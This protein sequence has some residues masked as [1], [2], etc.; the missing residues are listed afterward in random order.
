MEQ[1]S[2]WWPGRGSAP[3]A[4]E[5]YRQLAQAR[6]AELWLGSGSSSV[7]QQALRDFDRALA[8][9]FDKANPAGRPGYR[10]SRGIQGFAIRDT[11]TRRLSRR[12]G[13]VYVPKCGWVRFRWTQPL[14][15][16]L[17]VARVTCDRAG[18][19]HVCFPAPNRRLP[20]NAP[21]R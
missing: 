14:P 7:Q 3:S 15:D 4:V 16:K 19:W 13:E 20:E 21:G 2:W 12:W 8:A 1:Q 5:R 18:R 17:G 11:R 10:S 6:Q 9:F